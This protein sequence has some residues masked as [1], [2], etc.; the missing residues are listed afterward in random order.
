MP[1]PLGNLGDA[2]NPCR[3]ACYS[4]VT[5]W[6]PC[7]P[8]SCYPSVP[9]FCYWTGVEESQPLGPDLFLRRARAREPFAKGGRSAGPRGGPR[10]I[11]PPA[12]RSPAS[13]LE[14]RS[15]C[16]ARRAWG[17]GFAGIWF[18]A[19]GS[20][21]DLASHPGKWPSASRCPRTSTATSGRQAGG[22]SCRW[23]C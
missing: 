4:P 15:P 3:S 13:A 16:P 21:A 14:P 1:A 5:S 19:K 8:T 11:T 17:R 6:Y 2:R 18:A 23:L 7:V 12:T 20:G 10:S 9:T 22:T